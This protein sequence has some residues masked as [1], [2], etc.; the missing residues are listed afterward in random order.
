MKNNRLFVVPNNDAEA[1]RI[2]E[3]LKENNEKFLVT[4]QTWGASWSNLEDTIKK[5]IHEMWKQYQLGV[6]PK[7]TIYGVELQGE[8]QNILCENIDH[9]TYENDDRSNKL[10]SLEQVL[11]LLNIQKTSWDKYISANDT[12]YIPAM[13]KSGAIDIFIQ[14]IRA[15]DRKAQ[16]ITTEQE[17]QAV[18]AIKKLEKYGDL[19]I[20]RST[21]SKCSIYTDKLYSQYKNLLILSKDGESNFYGDSE[22]VEELFQSF[23]GWKGGNLE[24]GYGFWG[25]YAN[26][27]EIEKTVKLHLS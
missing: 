21:H 17:K 8:A 2:I 16:G 15:L 20:I 14:Q 11:N 4:S 9:H 25:G 3:I 23:K 5:E 22:I 12:G 10:S 18:E 1:M 19:T 7:T 24:E 6:T 26:Q 27:E 13:I